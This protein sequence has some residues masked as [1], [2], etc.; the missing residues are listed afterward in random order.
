MVGTAQL[1]SRVRAWRRRAGLSQAELAARVGVSRQALVAIEAGRQVPSTALSLELGRALRCA[2]EDLFRLPGPDRIRARCGAAAIDDRVTLGRVDGAWTAHPIDSDARPADGVVVATG[3]REGEVQPFSDPEA[4]VRNVLVAGCAPLLGVWTGCLEG[5]AEARGTWIRADSTR[6]LDLLAG[7]RVHLAGV[8]LAEASDPRRHPD[9]V[10]ERFPAR[11]MAVIGLARW[12]Q[13]LAVRPGNPL[14]IRSIEDVC[15]PDVRFVD[16]AVG[17]GA[18]QLVA[19]LL[20]QTSDGPI[21][22]RAL[23]AS[24]HAEVARLIRLGVADAGV[25]FEGVALRE[26]L[27]FI[28]LAEERFDLFLPEERRTER[29]V[30]RI[31][32]VLAARA[33]R[34]QAERLAGYDFGT[35][36]AVET[37]TATRA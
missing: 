28:P 24:S 31:L 21:G 11:A 17:S 9:L 12:R 20:G 26:G 14:G 19:R 23:V 30:A 1:T 35:M 25:A 18:H 2:V 27:P 29:P 3:D 5:D 13:G 15:R 37:I 8:H 22:G 34:T 33:F 6:A 10:R 4:C 36:G 7:G 32:D 16:R